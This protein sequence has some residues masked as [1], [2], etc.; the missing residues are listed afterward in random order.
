[1]AENENQDTYLDRP[2]RR[3]ASSKATKAIVAFLLVVS[4]A[5]VLIITVG[6][7]DTLEGAIPLQIAYIVLYLGMAFLVMRW[8]RGVLPLAA[9]LAIVLLI[10]AAVSGPAWF[11]RDKAGLTDPT[12]DEDILGLLSLILVPIQILLIA[13]AMRGFQQAWNVEV[14]RTRDEHPR[15]RRAAAGGRLAAP[16][17]SRASPG[18]GIGRHC[19]LKSR[20]SKGRAGSNP[21]PG[22]VR[23]TRKERGATRRMSG[24]WPN[25]SLSSPPSARSAWSSSASAVT[26]PPLPI[27]LWTI[28]GAIMA[29]PVAVNLFGFA[30]WL[31][32]VVA[33]TLG[34]TAYAAGRR[35]P[36]QHQRTSVDQR[37][38]RHRLPH[39]PR[40]GARPAARG[41]A[42]AWAS[43]TTSRSS[44]HVTGGL[45]EVLAAATGAKRAVE[46]GTAIGVSARSTSP[47]RRARDVVRGRPRAARG[48]QGV[49][50]ARRR[51]APTCGC[52]TRP[53]GSPSSSRARFD[54]AFIDGPKSGYGTHLDRS[55]ASLRPG[56]LLLVDN[57]LMGGGAATGEP[58]NQ[59]GAESVD[60]I[61]A[62]ND[63]LQAARGPA[64]DLP[65]GRRWRGAGG[66]TVRST[67]H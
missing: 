13:F 41:D 32:L 35:R 56:G 48:G 64:R 11:D 55:S 18:G 16:Y 57:V 63:G 53:R 8:N 17:P 47:R 28:A 50:Q 26:S 30:G 38:R 15:R 36:A 33:G 51:R 1:M 34:C 20:C 37:T 44:N 21:A 61:R 58:T 29:G 65:R 24:A 39:R 4:A 10:F 25:S 5:I 6:G 14:E 12:L 23:C 43:A 46:V 27:V 9:A 22:M 54:L 52:R 49:P 2:N 60:L 66:A 19:G 42:G 59:W 67:S 62:F 7:W 31:V 3:K 40:A 45:L